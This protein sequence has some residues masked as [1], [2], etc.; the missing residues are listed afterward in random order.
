[1]RIAD[2]QTIP[3]SKPKAAQTKAFTPTCV[4]A[5]IRRLDP[6]PGFR[7]NT[8][9]S[10]EKS[11]LDLEITAQSSPASAVQDPSSASE[12]HDQDLG[13]TRK[14]GLA[15]ALTI[16]RE[17]LSAGW[18]SG[19][20][21]GLQAEI[22]RRYKIG[23]WAMREAVRILE[24]RG[25]A[26]MR[27]GRGGGLMVAA[28]TLNN[29]VKPCALYL[30][31]QHVTHA[32]LYR[33]ARVVAEITA[34]LLFQ[35]FHTEAALAV[36]LSATFAETRDLLSALLK[37]T[38]NPALSLVASILEAL[39]GPRPEIETT[40]D[41][42][43]L[44]AI[45][46]SVLAGETATVADLVC[47]PA[48][49]P[50]CRDL[51]L[52][53]WIKPTGSLN[54]CRYSTQLAFKML[55]EIMGPHQ[56]QPTFLG[57][58]WDIAHRYGFSLESVRQASRILEDMGVI[59]CRLGRSGGLFTHKPVLAEILPQTFAYLFHQDVTIADALL[60][61]DKLDHG[62]SRAEQVDGLNNPLGRLLAAMFDGFARQAHL[63]KNPAIVH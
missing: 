51:D 16:E 35:R 31:S 15:V 54:A 61:A 33:T 17:F 23:R 8:L 40:F 14:L 2:G 6:D 41:P 57:S 45:S 3:F 26:D 24:M 59:E 11:R 22:Q 29:V 38:G 37:M 53:R 20:M 60:A 10:I 36:E 43:R 32:H 27:R 58:E 18:P 48:P 12:L 25:S 46:R 47:G 21:F 44:A 13:R 55:G 42:R 1:M 4:K 7:L 39:A 19:V 63:E 9:A 5:S 50:T 62:L 30:L 34:E 28:P 49:E 52:V 56:S